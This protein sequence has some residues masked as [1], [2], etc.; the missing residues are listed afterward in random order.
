MQPFGI[1]NFLKA[2]LP[3]SEGENPSTFSTPAEGN[4]PS[5]QAVTPPPAVSEEPTGGAHAY[6]AFLDRHEAR[7]RKVRKK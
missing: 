1:L 6:Q 5:E 7:A 3:P 4:L 2:F